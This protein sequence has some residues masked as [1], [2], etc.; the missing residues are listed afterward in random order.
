MTKLDA[1]MTVTIET[2]PNPQTLKF[3]FSEN[4]ISSPF[5]CP[6]AQEAEKS[7]LAAK[8]FGF[9]W[10]ESVYLGQDF[11]AITKQNWVEWEILAQPL[12][13]LIQSHIQNGEELVIDIPEADDL[14]PD[15]SEIVKAIKRA[16]HTEIRPIVAYDGGDIEFVKYENQRLQLKFKG[17]CA[18]CPSKSITLKQGIEVRLQELFPEIIEVYGA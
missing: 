7:P 15:D 4:L 10:T 9:P 2:T 5:D 13:A 16:L 3:K 12:A 6:N 11:I 1:A 18:G 8:I 14:N 17:A